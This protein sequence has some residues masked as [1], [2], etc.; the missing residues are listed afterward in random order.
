[1]G[2]C[3]SS[4]RK[5]QNRP[6]A[7]FNKEPDTLP[8]ALAQ[9]EDIAGRKVVIGVFDYRAKEDGDLS[10]RKG[11]R[12]VVISDA[13]PDWWTVRHLVTGQD[14][15][16]PSNYVAEER[17][18]ESEDWFFANTPRRE[19]EKLL[20]AN[21][22]PRGTFL[23]RNSEHSPTG[24]S[25]SVRD[26]EE[27]KGDHVKHYKIKA[28]PDKALYHIAVNYPFP[29][30]QSLVQAYSKNSHGLCCTL[31]QPC[32]KPR[33]EMWDLSPSH[34]DQWEIDRNEISLTK[35]L[36]SGNFGEVWLGTCKNQQVAIKTLKPG[37]MS[38]QAFL[39]E[40]AIMKKFRHKNLVALYAVCSKDE[41][42]YI[43]QEFMKKG[44]L[45]DYMRNGEG[46]C[47]LTNDLIHISAQIASGMEYL[48]KLNLIHRDIA[49]RNI[50]VTDNNL[51]KICDFGLARLI[52]DDEYCPKA[53]GR[54]PIKWTAPEAIMYNR[55]TIKS[56]VWSY[57][58]L[59][60]EIFTYGQVPYP[61]MNT[62]DVIDALERGYRMSKPTNVPVPDDVYNV[63]T[64]CWDATPEKRPTFDYLK[65]FFEDFSVSTEL[66]YRE[67]ENV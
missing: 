13:N 12:M 49:A 62:R 1:M 14:G 57:G 3:C 36:G 54:F 63:M 21:G 7:S 41:P 4:C 38:P 44:S 43:I 45:L 17:S 30:L 8:T 59:L 47:L 64:L 25:L 60:M 42:M 24:Y 9:V 67:P 26:V 2:C 66:A 50:L 58:I 55:F 61:G 51:V 65:H 22:N 29:N 53:G 18:I 15:L 16:I 28:S 27:T 48:E 56:D 32:P 23:I 39:E 46:K 31:T 6:S 19:A 34:R 40:A 35:K 20:L 5:K 33:P 52:E 37:S 11:D 10:F